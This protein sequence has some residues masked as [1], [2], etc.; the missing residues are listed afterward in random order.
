MTYELELTAADYSEKSLRAYSWSAV[1]RYFMP[2]SLCA[3][4]AAW[5]FATRMLDASPQAAL[6][7]ALVFFVGTLGFFSLN[8]RQ[9]F[10][11]TL[12]SHYEAPHRKGILGPHT[13]ELTD[14]GLVSVGPLHQTFRDWRSITHVV[15]TGS[16][17]LFHTAFGVVYVLPNR[18]VADMKALNAFVESRSTSGRL[19]ILRR[20]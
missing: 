15:F 19:A 1:F 16:Q 7:V 10:L 14:A 6:V 13:L 11:A 12:R 8:W 5:L 20:P 3:A 18:A 4:L 9:K 17:V 2:H